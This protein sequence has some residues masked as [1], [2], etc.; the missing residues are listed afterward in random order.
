MKAATL[1]F[2]EDRFKRILIENHTDLGKCCLKILNSKAAY[3]G[4]DI[5][6]GKLPSKVEPLMK[7]KR[8][9]GPAPGLCPR[10]SF[11]RLIQIY[12]PACNMAFV[13]DLTKLEGNWRGSTVLRD[14]LTSKRFIAHNAVFEI[15]HFT[16]QGFPNF[17]IECSMILSMLID[18]AEHARFE[19][20]EDDEEEEDGLAVYKHIGYG[21]DAV[22]GRL[23]KIHVA[24]HEQT[25]DWNRPVLTK[26]QINYAALDAFLTWKIG[27]T[28][29]P[30]LKKWRM[31]RTYRVFRAM[32]H[33]ISDI[34]LNGLAIDSNAHKRLVELWEKDHKK[35]TYGLI[36]HFPGDINVRSSKQMNAW[37]A[38]KYPKKFCTTVWPKTKAY[39][40]A[41]E[42]DPKTPLILSFGKQSLKQVIVQLKLHKQ[43]TENLE[44]LLSF[45]KTDKLLSTYGETLARIVHPMTGRL[46][47][48]F[49]SETHTG[50]LSCR[51]PNL[52]NLPRDEAVRK[53][54]MAPLP[55]LLL[56]A[57][58][59]QIETR[60]QAAL[61]HDPVMTR[62]FAKGVDLHE[63]ILLVAFNWRLSEMTD[64]VKRKAM[65]QSG[66]AINF[67]L[68]FGMGWKKL[69]LYALTEY[70]VILTEEQARQAFN[71]Y[72]YKLYKV[73]SNW[74]E[75]QRLFWKRHGY[76]RTPMGMVCKLSEKEYYTCAVNRQVQGGAA[77]IMKL[78]MIYFREKIPKTAQLVSTVH[79]EIIVECE[80]ESEAT[81]KLLERCMTQAFTKVF[82]DAPTRGLVEAKWGKNWAECKQ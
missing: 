34:E 60:V 81:K 49:M 7:G 63:Y 79:D 35:F 72:H 6:T 48:S 73:Y 12:D 58:Y 82:P 71:T 33:V 66:K 29:F 70:D 75:Q 68:A 1:E 32:N 57:D 17:K 43:K 67:G 52:Q 42:S 30:E 19:K 47:S 59:S 23:F 3:L 11:I 61:S 31:E 46:H 76:V 56:T 20:S 50:R 44:T 45:K 15:K 16:R 25:S 28:F 4:I 53:I 74:C 37:A 27:H 22:C 10:L 14:V 21:L 55:K 39:Y 36:R 54:F 65:R 24:K 78:A 62:A 38:E 77:E 2:G 41:L 13:F 9:I 40:N 80:R 26:S 51:E 8:I 18:R 5:E 69:R 64:Q